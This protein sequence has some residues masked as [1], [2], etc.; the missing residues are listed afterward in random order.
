MK[1]NDTKFTPGPWKCEHTGDHKRY[2]IG[3]GQSLFGTHVAEVYSDDTDTD[4]AAANAALIQHAPDLLAALVALV[5]TEEASKQRF[6]VGEVIALEAAMQTARSALQKALSRP[7]N[8][9]GVERR[10]Q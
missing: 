10:G 5:E 4:E 7:S 8:N 9:P 6:E 3:D 2:V 1:T